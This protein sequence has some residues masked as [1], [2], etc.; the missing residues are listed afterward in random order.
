MPTMIGRMRFLEVTM[1]NLIER[2]RNSQNRNDASPATIVNLSPYDE[3]ILKRYLVLDLPSSNAD[4]D[5][6]KIV[7]VIESPHIHEVCH[8]HPLAGDSGKKVT[9][10][11]LE[12]MIDDSEQSKKPIGCLIV[13]GQMPWLSLINVSQLPLQKKYI[14]KPDKIVRLSSADFYKR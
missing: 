3:E 6:V 13:S 9:K 12:T 10:K 5:R 11:Y 7:F 2:L 14:V 1:M 8:K 4:I